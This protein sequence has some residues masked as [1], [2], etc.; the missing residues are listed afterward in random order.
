L[1]GVIRGFVAQLPYGD[2]Q[3]A[4]R[5]CWVCLLAVQWLFQPLFY[6]DGLLYYFTFLVI[7]LTAQEFRLGRLEPRMIGG[8]SELR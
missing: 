7:G 5:W 8:S 1:W 6:S 4:L 2:W 3:H